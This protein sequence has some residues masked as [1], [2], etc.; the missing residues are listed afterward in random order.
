MTRCVFPLSHVLLMGLYG[1]K[2]NPLKPMLFNTQMGVLNLY[3]IKCWS[4]NTIM[5]YDG[6]K[7]LYN[8]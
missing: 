2:S 6:Y 5:S 8:L 1:L 4:N 7:G 3:Q